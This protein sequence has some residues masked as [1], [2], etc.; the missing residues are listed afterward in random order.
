MTENQSNEGL[1][2]GSEIFNN[3]FISNHPVSKIACETNTAQEMNSK[4]I[5]SWF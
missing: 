3:N 2:N 1:L 4:F 5:A